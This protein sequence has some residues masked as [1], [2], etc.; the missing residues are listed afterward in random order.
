M[1][2]VNNP[3]DYFTYLIKTGI[4][5]GVAQQCTLQMIKTVC[6]MAYHQEYERLMGE[7]TIRVDHDD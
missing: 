2:Q 4:D 1:E 6:S 5:E 3:N 7:W